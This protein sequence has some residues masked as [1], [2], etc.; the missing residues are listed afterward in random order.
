MRTPRTKGEANPW[1][2]TLLFSKETHPSRHENVPDPWSWRLVSINSQPQLR[3]P[4]LPLGILI[5]LRLGIAV[6][7]G[8]VG[9]SLPSDRVVPFAAT[10]R[11]WPRRTSVGTAASVDPAH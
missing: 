9:H 6:F 2:T 7:R 1:E 3:V 8:G 11:L 4:A 5:K 10:V